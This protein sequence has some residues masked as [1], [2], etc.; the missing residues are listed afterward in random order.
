MLLTV[1][2]DRIIA[3]RLADDLA[4]VEKRFSAELRSE[5]SCVNSLVGHIE[6]YRGKM[7]RP[8]LVLVSGMATAGDPEVL[9]EEHQIVATVMEMV[10]MATLVHD[11]VLDEAELR[12][13]G[14]T[15]NRLR[16]NETAIMLGDYLV[17]HAYH[18]CAGLDMPAV[19]RV[20]SEA[21]NRVCEGE[22]HQLA[23]RDNWELDEKTYFQIIR[24]KTARLCG[25]C[26]RLGAAL[27]QAED[28]VVEA[29]YDYGEKLGLAFQIVDDVL[30]LVGSEDA[31]GK[32]LG[33][34]LAKRKLT[35][36]L[37]HFL[38]QS[39]SARKGELQRLLEASGPE[40][41]LDPAEVIGVRQLLLDSGSVAYT[42][43]VAADLIDR[44]KAALEIVA[45]SPA[46]A[47]LREVADAV[48]VRKF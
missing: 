23:N 35:L 42:R 26:C 47:L 9:T 37:I 43:T 31:V 11:D 8:T 21:T 16:G 33:L 44:A 3:E 28:Q 41:R 18:L 6:R 22:L 14:K 25:T 7:L 46:R 12:R 2:G 36:P 40:H 30:D 1:S 10:H 45:D 15:V 24:S 32:T 20:I 17:S 27:S 13:T 4:G 48:L 38:T 19:A 39:A 29:L 34:D 5:L